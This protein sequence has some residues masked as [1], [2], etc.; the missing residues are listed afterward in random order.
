M[1]RIFNFNS[2]LPLDKNKLKKLET[3]NDKIIGQS[4]NIEFELIQT[5]FDVEHDRFGRGKV[6][7]V[8]GAGASKKATVFFE[9]IGQKQL[10][11]KFAKLRVI[12]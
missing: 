8:E 1:L 5:G 2:G 7:Q 4:E 6:L 9:N 12:K 10:L 3:V 11:L